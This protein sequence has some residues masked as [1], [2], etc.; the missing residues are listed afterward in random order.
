MVSAIETAVRQAPVAR[1]DAG[2]VPGKRLAHDG[3]VFPA[4]SSVEHGL[5][6]LGALDGGVLGSLFDHPE[7][8][9]AAP[10]RRQQ[11][12]G[13][14]RKTGGKLRLRSREVGILQMFKRLGLRLV[15]SGLG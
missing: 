10:M 14:G 8:E 11:E 9:E 2:G 12:D 15:F 1:I 6:G 13:S 7:Q 5:G 3:E 4:A